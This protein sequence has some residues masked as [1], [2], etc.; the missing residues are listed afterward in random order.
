[1]GEVRKELA[2][3]ASHKSERLRRG[4][5]ERQTSDLQLVRRRPTPFTFWLP[6]TSESA[7]RRPKRTRRMREHNPTERSP[8]RRIAMN[9]PSR[10]CPRRNTN[11]SSLETPRL[12]RPNTRRAL[13]AHAKPNSNRP[14]R[15]AQ[16]DPI[17]VRIQNRRLAF[18]DILRNPVPH[19]R[20]ASLR[21][22]LAIRRTRPP[23]ERPARN[24]AHRTSTTVSTQT[25]VRING[26]LNDG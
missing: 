24:Y 2:C 19:T 6:H 5:S 8:P 21:S 14:A 26:S 22:R 4:K 3:R 11:P 17:V 10:R 1:M 15:T 12:L 16:P 7:S 20:S 25:F 23:R 18:G 9:N 13:D